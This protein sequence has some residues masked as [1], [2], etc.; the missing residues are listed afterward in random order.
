MEL[1]RSTIPRLMKQIEKENNIRKS[2]IQCQII[3]FGSYGLGAHL[4]T[5]DIDVVFLSSVHVRRRDFF[6]IFA[7]ILKKQATVRDILVSFFFNGIVGN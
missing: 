2:N 5:A 7:E 6:R 1:L 3:P 4:A